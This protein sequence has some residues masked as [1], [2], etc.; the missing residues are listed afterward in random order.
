MGGEYGGD[1]VTRSVQVQFPSGREVLSSYWGFLDSGGLVL[2]EAVDLNEGENV[3]LDV[4]IKSLKQSYTFA[5]R[6]VKRTSP[7]TAS[8]P[9][10]FVAFATGQDQQGLLNAAW[11]DSHDVP[12]RKHRRYAGGG[13]VRYA[14]ADRPKE[15]QRGHV[16]DVSPGGC[17]LK[18][19]LTLPVGARLV[20]DAHGIQLEGQVRWV[21]RGREMGIEFARPGLVV[22]ALIDREPRYAPDNA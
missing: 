21:T 3:L 20:V 11:A 12:Q 1:G 7:T 10:A 6:V 4:R 2:S 13:E 18:G 15:L 9:R 8:E 5:G 17:R 19:P 22:Q 14:A 16:L